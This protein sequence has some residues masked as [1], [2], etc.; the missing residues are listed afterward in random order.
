MKFSAMD[1]QGVGIWG[2]EVIKEHAVKTPNSM[3][4][5]HV[6]LHRTMSWLSIQTLCAFEIF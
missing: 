2:N 4:F 3:H 5:I 6:S 1:I